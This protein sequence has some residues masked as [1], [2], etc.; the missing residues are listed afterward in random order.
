MS[1][2]DAFAKDFVRQMNAHT[3][4]RY[5]WKAGGT[6]LGKGHESVDIRGLPKNKRGKLIFVE[7]ELRK[8]APL[9]NVVK[10]WRWIREQ[11]FKGR[12]VFVQAFSKYYKKGDTKRSNAEVVGKELERSTRNKYISIPFAY[13]PYRHGKQGAGRRRH[14]A[15]GLA[16]KVRRKLK[17]AGLLV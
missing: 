6:P 1:R 2:T 10:V 17:V 14:H 15:V 11:E 13:N 4:G 5:V 7:V 8:D 12:F 3:R 16:D 9:T